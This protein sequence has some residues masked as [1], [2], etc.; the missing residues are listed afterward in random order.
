M[1]TADM[2][3]DMSGDGKV[4]EALERC[5]RRIRQDAE[6][7]ERESCLFYCDCMDGRRRRPSKSC[8]SAGSRSGCMSATAAVFGKLPRSTPSGN[9][10]R[11]IREGALFHGKAM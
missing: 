6:L 1:F 5:E 2:A 7:G 3:R 8:A 9:H 11:G 4:M 10:V